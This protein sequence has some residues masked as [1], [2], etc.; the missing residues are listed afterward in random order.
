MRN[1]ILAIT[2]IMLLMACS[3][4]HTHDDQHDQNAGINLNE[5][6]KWKV[7]SEMK[8][9]VEKGMQVLNEFIDQKGENYG[10]LAENLKAQNNALIQ[11]CTMEGE[12]HDELHK[13]L[14]PHIKLVE[15]LSIA[16]EKEDAEEILVQLEVSYNTY[17]KY[18]E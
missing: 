18:F 4:N 16:E 5:G 3:T 6:K 11:S 2:G 15:R 9:D 14:H 8:P 7:N 10:E 13:W 1:S 12:S 17:Q